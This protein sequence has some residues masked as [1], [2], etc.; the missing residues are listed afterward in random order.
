MDWL[1]SSSDGDVRL[2]QDPIWR[3]ATVSNGNWQY[4]RGPPL[5]DNEPLTVTLRAA[6][7][8]GNLSDILQQVITV[9]TRAPQLTL[10]QLIQQVDLDAYD[11]STVITGTIAD[12]SGIASLTVRQ[13]NPNGSESVH[14]L[15]YDGGNWSFAPL[16]SQSGLHLLKVEAVEMVGNVRPTTIVKLNVTKATSDYIIF[17]P[18]LLNQQRD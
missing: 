7:N 11:G 4:P 17:L 9:D 10:T 5:I 13:V 8:V 1:Q 3:R 2:G 18:A 6:D 12:G 16:L 14:A 15:E